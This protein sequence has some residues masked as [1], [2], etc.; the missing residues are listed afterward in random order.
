MVD[1]VSGECDDVGVEGVDLGDD[2]FEEVVIF[3]WIV[4]EVGELDDG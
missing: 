4:V 1:V 3:F 2:F